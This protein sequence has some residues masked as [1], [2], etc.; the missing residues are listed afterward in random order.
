[1]PQGDYRFRAEADAPRIRIGVGI[2]TGKVV[3]GNIGGRERI[4]YTVIGDT[5]N[6]A[7]RLEEKT[8]EIAG[9]TLISAATYRQAT[10]QIPLQ[11]EYLPQ[12]HVKGKKDALGVY[13]LHFSG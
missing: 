4:E 9:N 7:S 12:L 6:L 1:M 2:A 10:G 8:K 13:A 3:A 11:A 5:V